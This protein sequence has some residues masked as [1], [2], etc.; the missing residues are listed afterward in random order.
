MQTK[1]IICETVQWK[2][3]KRGDLLFSETKRKYSLV[4]FVSNQ[5][6]PLGLSGWT[7]IESCSSQGAIEKKS[8]RSHERIISSD[9][10]LVSWMSLSDSY[11]L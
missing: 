3:L 9:W 6:A 7:E 10:K 4:L 11:I 5:D 1:E 8:Y 2:D